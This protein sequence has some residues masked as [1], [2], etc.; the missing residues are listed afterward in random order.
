MEYLNSIQVPFD[1]AVKQ[2]VEQLR[3]IANGNFTTPTGSEKRKFGNIVYDAVT[4]PVVDIR[5]ILDKQV[6]RDGKSA[7]VFPIPCKDTWEY[8]AVHQVGL[9]E[10]ASVQSLSKLQ[11]KYSCLFLDLREPTQWE[12]AFGWARLTWPPL[13]T[14]LTLKHTRQVPG[15]SIKLPLPMLKQKNQDLADSNRKAGEFLKQKDITNS[16][17]QCH[18]TLAH[19]RSHGVTAVASYGVFLNKK[20]PVSVTALLFSDKFAALEAHPGSVDDE[21]V[22]SKNQW[23]LVAIWTAEGAAAKEANTL[24]QLVQEGK[25]VQLI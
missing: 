7:V 14:P 18:V 1:Y 24:P 4:M 11:D 22:V 2:V 13:V 6:K 15:L 3:S 20:V 25:A 16:L 10:D 19:K 9:I 5:S 17:R 12:I 23:P 8:D 21:K